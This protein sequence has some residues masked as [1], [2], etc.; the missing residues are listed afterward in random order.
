MNIL[1]VNCGNTIYNLVST[2]VIKSIK[3][4]TP[5]AKIS[6]IVGEED[7]KKIFK[8]NK[9]I[10]RIY[11]PSEIPDVNYD[12]CINLYP[13]DISPLDIKADYFIGFG[14]N[15]MLNKIIPA[16]IEDKLLPRK[17]SLFNIIHWAA[18]LKWQGESYDIA[19]YPRSKQKK[20]RLGIGSVHNNIKNYIDENF[21]YEDMKIYYLPYKKNIL[22][23]MDEINKC[24][25][26][27]T[28]DLLT[29]HLSIALRKFVVFLETTTMPF[30]IEFFG[31]GESIKVP[32]NIFI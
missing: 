10:Y 21:D 17:T 18:G 15:P 13:V 26:I 25:R 4:R 19:Y 28:D 27:V 2:S 20:T 1:I 22:K 11:C 32:R 8:Y 5:H 9:N 31:N 30:Q 24:A 29:C 6:W 12:M 3:N 7:D 23:R 16:L 14:Y